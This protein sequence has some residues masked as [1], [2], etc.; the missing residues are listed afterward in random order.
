MASAPTMSTMTDGVNSLLL[1]PALT[2]DR[3]IRPSPT[4]A[5]LD[6]WLPLRDRA[7]RAVIV[8]SAGAGLPA[9]SPSPVPD[10]RN[11]GEDGDEQRG[12]GQRQAHI[13]A[14]SRE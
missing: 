2:V 11:R 5:I 9:R 12:P 3:P 7:S 14:R 4:T 10:H 8:A 1:S 13:A 6:I